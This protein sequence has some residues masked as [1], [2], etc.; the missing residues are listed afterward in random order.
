MNSLFG[1]LNPSGHCDCYVI[2]SVNHFK[3]EN[4]LNKM[5]TPTSELQKTQRIGIYKK[6]GNV[7]ITWHWGRLLVTIFTVEKQ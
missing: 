3:H 2:V 1:K 6:T 7:V 4:L 5:L